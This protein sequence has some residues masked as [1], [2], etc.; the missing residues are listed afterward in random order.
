MDKFRILVATLATVSASLSTGAAYAQN[1]RAEMRDELTVT[2][3]R[4]EENVQDIPVAVS[5]FSADE[6]KKRNMREL[7]DIALA[8]PGFSFEDFGGGFGVPTI[9][10]GSQLRIQDLDQTTSIFLDGIY[11]PRQY[12]FDFG[13][14]GFESIEVVK[15]PQSALFGRNAFLGAVNYVSTRATEELEASATATLGSD[16]LREIAASVSGP[17]VDGLIGGRALL[18]YSEFDGTWNNDHPN[19]GIDFGTNGTTDN[20]GGWENSTVGFNFDITP[21][22]DWTVEL[23]FYRVERFQEAD[24]N[25]R[26]EA[27]AGDTNCSPTFFGGNRFYCG[28]IPNQ[29]TPLP[30]G[31]AP[32][33]RF[34]IDPRSYNLDVTSDLIRVGVDYQ[35]SD[36]WSFDYNFGYSDS[37]VTSAGPGDRDAV[38]GSS[39]FFGPGTV[40]YF[41][42]TPNGTNQ[43][44]S[45]EVKVNFTSGQWTAFVGLFTSTIKDF[46]KFD[47]GLGPLLGTQ[48]L[49]IDPR[50]GIIGIPKLSLTNAR[51]E[52]TTDA[53]F[54][55][56]GWNS[57]DGKLNIGL[58]ARYA[59]EEKKLDSNT[60]TTT[61]PQFKDS[62]SQF[63]P[64]VTVDYRFDDERMVYASI[65]KGVKSG[66]FN[67]T[68]FDESQRSFD[69]DQN[70]TYEIGSKNDLLDGRFRVNAALYFTDWDDLQI[71]SSPIGIPPGV[72]PPA[73]VDNT[74]GAEIWGLELDG[75]YYATDH[76]LFDYALSFINSEYKSGAV[77]SRIGLI[78]GCDG[79]VCPADGSIGG[80]ELQR[81]PDTQ[82]AV[83]SEIDGTLTGDWTWSLRGDVTYQSKQFIDELNLAFVPERTLVNARFQVDNGRWNAALWA[84]NLFDEEYVANS[85]FI[86]TP[87]GT[88][89]VPTF[90]DRAT[91]GLTV[92]YQL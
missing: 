91:Y 10:G 8:T 56:V 38:L 46:D 34:V 5:A 30:G 33:S 28:E 63:T 26:V 20:L 21:T 80:N 59:D 51:T 90:G 75:A 14:I 12:M 53:I 36:A 18:S 9:R 87:F 43:F 57:A 88:S 62:W 1:T 4:V 74:A 15:G 86:A 82:I 71:N 49:N 17:I 72:T 54:G 41:N 92:T 79:I 32:G 23:D 68:V 22:D 61:D 70:W 6:M 39:N 55:R 13:T 2:A 83:G 45:H 73:I 58:E 69:P 31:A 64:R 19:A 24:A 77:S 42:A 66:G 27:S 67:N 40:N 37:E 52:V 29:F 81:Q 3:R 7:E 16:E 65:A 76:L 25:I 84:R 50:R 48:P 47:L 85:F 44:R 89:Y 35:L 11:L 78:G 60:T